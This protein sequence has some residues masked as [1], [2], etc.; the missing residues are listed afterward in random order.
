M[1]LLGTLVRQIISSANF[2]KKHFS[3]AVIPADA[4][5]DQEAPEGTRFSL[6]KWN[7]GRER[8]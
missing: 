1:G 4:D 2:K 3:Y 7:A 8:N 5:R 6:R